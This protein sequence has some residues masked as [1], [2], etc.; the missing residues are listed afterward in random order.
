MSNR[1]TPSLPTQGNAS[2]CSCG[3]AQEHYHTPQGGVRRTREHYNGG[4]RSG[5]FTD[6][7]YIPGIKGGARQQILACHFPEAPD[8]RVYCHPAPFSRAS[9]G[10]EYHAMH[11]AYGHS[12]P[13]ASGRNGI[14]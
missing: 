14:F 13:K 10:Q 12:R 7:D 2:T 4:Q 11:Q 6:P 8:E 9:S 5:Q 3:D 1:R